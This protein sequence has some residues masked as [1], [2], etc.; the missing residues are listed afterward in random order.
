MPADDV[1]DSTDWL[2]T[3]LSGLYAVESALRCEVCKDFYKTPMI[4]SCAHTFCS[5]CIRRALA[6][7]SKCP[8]CRATDQEL[9]LRSNWS[10]EQTVA[11]FS[12]TRAE[13]LKFARS[14]SIEK[15]QSPKRKAEDD[16]E[17]SQ[18]EPQSKRLR[19]SARLSSRADVTPPAPSIDV[20]E[21]SE[22]EDFEPENNDGLVPCPMCQR[23]M[24]EWQVFAHLESCPGPDAAAAAASPRKPNINTNTTQTQQAQPTGQMQRQ[25]QKT[26][27]RLP[28]LSYSIFKEQALRKKLAELGI[29]NQGPRPLLERRHKEWLTIWNANCDAAQ[30]RRRAA[31]LHDLDVWERT[32]GGRAPT[33]TLGRAAQAAA[34]IRDKDFD[35]AAWAS[36][37]GDSFKDLIADARRS[38]LAAQK[39][40]DDAA[41]EEERA[42]GE[43]DGDDGGLNQ[44]LIRAS[45]DLDTAMKA[46]YEEP[47]APISSQ[48]SG[49]M[50]EQHS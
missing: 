16:E 10:M 6:N 9:K 44:E 22:D 48:T 2:S 18:P 1:A 36:R 41:A 13:A 50:Q 12:D 17:S 21:D 26:L 5:I 30:P 46:A 7:D 43:N 32:Q 45:P 29:S 19:S 28:S 34:A 11:A 24:K 15:K 25:Q 4:T 37:H 3:P 27:E 20:V 40:S 47:A 31:L 35:G 33:A 49:F 38:R 14:A 23:R 39:K 8:L 42:D